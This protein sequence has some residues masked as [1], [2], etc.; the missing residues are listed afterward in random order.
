MPTPDELKYFIALKDMIAG[1]MGPWK[2][3]DGWYDP[4]DNATGVVIPGHIRNFRDPEAEMHNFVRLPLP[5]DPENPERGLVGMINGTWLI[6]KLDE[7]GYEVTVLF[8]K[9]IEIFVGATPTLALLKALAWQ[10]GV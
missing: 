4:M 8:K 3:H 9:G 2:W 6:Q 10:E 1:K 5:I 7:S